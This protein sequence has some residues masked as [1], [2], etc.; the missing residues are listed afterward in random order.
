ME[1]KIL[2]D[3]KGLMMFELKDATHAFC[4]ILKEA[5]ANDPDVSVASYRLDH[6]FIGKP[7]FI[8]EAKDPRKALKNAIANLRKTN[9]TLRKALKNI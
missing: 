5:L 1:I 9:D 3:E 2:K 7:T 6:P 4:N 8:I